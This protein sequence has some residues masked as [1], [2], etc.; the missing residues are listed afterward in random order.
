MRQ[1][2][3]HHPLWGRQQAP[4]FLTVSAQRIAPKSQAFH[5]CVGKENPE[6]ERAFQ[7]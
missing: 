7:G 6:V 2:I 5:F 3:R 4:T 1:D